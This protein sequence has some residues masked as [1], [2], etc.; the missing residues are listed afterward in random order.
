MMRKN[1]RIKVCKA[2]LIFTNK[3]SKRLVSSYC[4]GSAVDT[5]V[6]SATYGFDDTSV[7]AYVTSNIYDVQIALINKELSHKI[8]QKNT[9]II[10]LLPL[11]TLLLGS[12][13]FFVVDFLK[14]YP[15]YI[16]SN[17]KYFVYKYIIKKQYRY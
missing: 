14:L 10:F 5:N 13:L 4:H 2:T 6:S 15:H 9:F 1:S 17:K 7:F 3:V 8:L 16:I 11:Q 12:L